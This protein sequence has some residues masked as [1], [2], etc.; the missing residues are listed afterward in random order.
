MAA[1]PATISPR[2]ARMAGS[3]SGSAMGAWMVMGFSWRED[4]T[5]IAAV[6]SAGVSKLEAAHSVSHTTSRDEASAGSGSRRWTV[7]SR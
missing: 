1:R 5:R 7:L 3:G 4:D 6:Q 2:R